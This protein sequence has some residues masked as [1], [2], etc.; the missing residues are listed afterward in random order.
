MDNSR[1]SLIAY[2][3]ILS[4]LV[5]FSFLNFSERFFP[6]LNSDQAVTILMTPGFT[7]PGDLY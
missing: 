6:L 4:L 7:I 3:I 2:Y 1:S 5:L